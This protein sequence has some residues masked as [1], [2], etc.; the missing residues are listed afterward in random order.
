MLKY[1]P[2]LGRGL[3]FVLIV[4]ALSGTSRALADNIYWQGGV[5][6]WFNA[7]N[8]K[9]QAGTNVVPSSSDNVHWQW[10]ADYF[11]GQCPGIQ[12]IHQ[13]HRLH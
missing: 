13:Q 11:D 9:D 2:H 4:I 3:A 1:Y 7:S 6:D 8:W 12:C 5:D 10:R